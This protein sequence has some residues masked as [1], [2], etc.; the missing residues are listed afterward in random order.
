M[1]PATHTKY[2][3]G[4]TNHTRVCHGKEKSTESF[5]V[6]GLVAESARNQWSRTWT[7]Q[8]EYMSDKCTRAHAYI[9]IDGTFSE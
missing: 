5:L 2:T 7:I 8:Q 4:N 3:I 6:C 9:N 1:Q